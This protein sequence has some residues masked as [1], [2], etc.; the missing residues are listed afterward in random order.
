VPD[1]SQYYRANLFSTS[2]IC[3]RIVIFSVGESREKGGEREIERREK[4][5]GERD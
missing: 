1:V 4:L 2:P 3:K 5:R